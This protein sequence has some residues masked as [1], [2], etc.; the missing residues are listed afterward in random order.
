MADAKHN[1]HDVEFIDEESHYANEMK[2]IRYLE[3]PNED[4]TRWVF[5]QDLEGY[6]E[7][8]E[9]KVHV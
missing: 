1:G 8:D 3:G 5:V 6:S 7:E 9:K 2:E 4:A